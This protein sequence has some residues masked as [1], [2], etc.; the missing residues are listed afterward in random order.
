MST[1]DEWVKYSEEKGVNMAPGTVVTVACIGWSGGWNEPGEVD[2]RGKLRL[3]RKGHIVHSITH[4]KGP[5]IPTTLER[6]KE[7]EQEAMVAIQQM[8]KDLLKLRRALHRLR[9]FQYELKPE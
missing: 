3:V 9:K 2:W 6:I 1:D 7:M 4:W 8:D 5:I